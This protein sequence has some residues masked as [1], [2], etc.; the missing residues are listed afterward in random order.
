MKI[1]KLQAITF[2]LVIL[3]LL[4]ACGTETSKNN[5]SE[6][7]E[8]ESEF[9]DEMKSNATFNSQEGL[10]YESENLKVYPAKIAK[11]FPNASLNLLT[12]K[13]SEVDKAGEYQFNFEVGNYELAEQ[14]P[15]AEERHC[16]NSQKGQHIH[17]ILNNAPYEA[18]YEASFNGTLMDGNNVVLGFLSR[19]Y[20]ESIK[21]KT[22]FVLKNYQIGET[23]ATFDLNA[24][25]L[26]YSRPKGSYSG[27]DAEKIL[28]DFYLVNTKLSTEGNQVKVMIDDH[29]FKV[30]R[31]EPYFVEGLTKGSHSFRIQLMDNEGNQIPGPFNDSGVREIEIG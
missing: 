29:E 12:P 31:W 6:A 26:F 20:H 5:N 28:L 19:S 1:Q 9:S 15:N 30:N 16:A 11:E 18:H 27:K 2:S 10:I 24:E 21:N 4:V 13:L 23:T 17:Y 25:H 8:N 14:T 3:M 7:L 22:A